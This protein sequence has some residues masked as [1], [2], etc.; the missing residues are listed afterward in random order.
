[1]RAQLTVFPQTL[2]LQ[3]PATAAWHCGS[4]H[5]SV[6][7]DKACRG[8]ADLAGLTVAG[9]ADS[10]MRGDICA[11]SCVPRSG[12]GQ[13]PAGSTRADAAAGS[14]RSVPVAALG[15]AGVPGVRVM[16]CVTP[17]LVQ[18]VEVRSGP[19]PSLRSALSG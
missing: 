10:R 8:R 12:A 15:A 18:M 3:S 6:Q 17:P 9:D 11:P 14:H 1:M 2:G 19:A 7:A 4:Q 5:S 13:L 16:V